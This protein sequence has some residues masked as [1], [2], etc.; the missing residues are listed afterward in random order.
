MLKK[1]TLLDARDAFY[2]NLYSGRNKIIDNYPLSLSPTSQELLFGAPDIEEVSDKAGNV[3]KRKV[4][5]AYHN[6]NVNFDISDHTKMQM[7]ASNVM[8]AK[9]YY[10]LQ[11]QQTDEV[12]ASIK[13]ELTKGGNGKDTS[14]LIHGG[15]DITALQ[16]YSKGCRVYELVKLSKERD[17]SVDDYSIQWFRQENTPPKLMLGQYLIKRDV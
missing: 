1:P 9:K 12:D 14:A 3:V 4:I 15:M 13:E 5:N 8:A 10:S 17:I 16:D 7:E 2:E 11:G 6:Y